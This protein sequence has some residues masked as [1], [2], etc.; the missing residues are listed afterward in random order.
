MM[1]KLVPANLFVHLAL[2][3]CG[4]QTVCSISLVV[5]AVSDLIVLYTGLLRQWIYMVFDLDIRKLGPA[6][7]KL[8]TSD[9][10]IFGLRSTIID[11]IFPVV[12]NRIRM[13]GRIFHIYSPA[14]YSEYFLY[15]I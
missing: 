12:P 3:I 7:C 15:S 13:G 4:N 2:V 9:F 8:H 5:L 1:T 10:L 14:L 11:R 6:I